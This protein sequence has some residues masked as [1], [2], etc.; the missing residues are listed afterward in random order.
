VLFSHFL[1]G[2]WPA[3]SGLSHALPYSWQDFKDPL[4]GPLHR[5]EPLHAPEQV[6]PDG[7]AVSD[8]LRIENQTGSQNP[9]KAQED[10][11]TRIAQ[12]QESLAL[13]RAA[14]ANERRERERLADLERIQREQQQ[15]ERDRMEKERERAESEAREQEQ[16]ARNEERA[17]KEKEDSRHMR[18]DE[19]QTNNRRHESQN[20]GHEQSTGEREQ[21]GHR[22]HKQRQ[23]HNNQ[24][25]HDQ[26]NDQSSDHHRD[27][28][29]Q[30]DNENKIHQRQPEEEQNTTPTSA[31]QQEPVT[32]AKASATEALAASP[33][34]VDLEI[35]PKIEQIVAA[36]VVI[37]TNAAKNEENTIP[38]TDTVAHDDMEACQPRT[39]AASFA[40]GDHVEGA[41]V[42]E[43][44]AQTA[45][46]VPN[47]ASTEACMQN[48]AVH[49]ADANTT[50]EV[51]D[52]NQTEKSGLDGE[53]ISQDQA[54]SAGG[55]DTADGNSASSEQ[56]INQEEASKNPIPIE[57]EEDQEDDTANTAQKSNSGGKKKNKKKKK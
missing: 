46:N 45:S 43:E 18:H 50:E 13:Q 48:T 12:E 56:K 34:D 49:E 21:H 33:E 36:P 39:D 47:K 4:L 44:D 25:P 35:Q 57:N 52:E 19:R 29:G 1:H 37:E 8:T 40:E 7:I 38:I 17:R 14:E 26:P 28:R 51:S 9:R 16:R 2:T 27:A 11:A 23:E 41:I 42:A 22:D 5:S 20:D 31:Q 3:S 54:V 24:K 32:D 15:E 6:R 10:L 55:V 53:Q 30:R